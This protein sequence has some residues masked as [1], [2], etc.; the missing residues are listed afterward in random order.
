MNRMYI[1]L[2]TILILS[3]ILLLNVQNISSNTIISAMDSKET[4]DTNKIIEEIVEK[5]DLDLN[6]PRVLYDLYYSG[7]VLRISRDVL[8]ELEIMDKSVRDIVFGYFDGKYWHALPIR[9][10][11]ERVESNLTTIYIIPQKIDRDT[12]VEIKLPSKQP[13]LVDP[14]EH[15]PEFARAANCR[16]ITLLDKRVGKPIGYIYLFIGGSVRWGTAGLQLLS[17]YDYTTV[18]EYFEASEPPAILD[19]MNKLGYSEEIKYYI[20]SQIQNTTVELGVDLNYN[21]T[22]EEPIPDKGGGGGDDPYGYNLVEVRPQPLESM[23][24]E[25]Y[26]FD[27]YNND[28]SFKIHAVDP[29]R[30]IK[31]KVLR[32]TIVIGCTN[33]NT[34]DKDIV[35]TLTVKISCEGYE[36]EEELTLLGDKPNILH[37]QF[38][39]SAYGVEIKE[40][41]IDMAI[42]PIVENEKWRFRIYPTFYINWHYDNIEGVR[43]KP[44]TIYPIVRAELHY[45]FNTNFKEAIHTIFMQPPPQLLSIPNPAN[46]Y[47]YMG[48]DV[49]TYAPDYVY[50]LYVRI[51]IGGFVCKTATLWSSGYS[52]GLN[53]GMLREDIALL[54]L[55]YK[56]VPITVKTYTYQDIDYYTDIEVYIEVSEYSTTSALT[57]T[58]Y[59]IKDEDRIL[60]TS[61]RE[62]DDRIWKE[63]IRFIR[64]TTVVTTTMEHLGVLQEK[65]Y[66]IT[67]SRETELTE[68]PGDRDYKLSID[69]RSPE[70]VLVCYDDYGYCDYIYNLGV[71]EA[72][73]DILFPKYMDVRDITRAKAFKFKLEGVLPELPEIPPPMAI[74][75]SKIPYINV[76][77]TAYDAFIW[78]YNMIAREEDSSLTITIDKDNDKITIHWKRGSFSGNEFEGEIYID[79]VYMSEPKNGDIVINV[80][81]RYSGRTV[82][83]TFI[84]KT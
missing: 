72:I 69:T 36:M 19:Y 54:S 80:E 16:V 8:K 47:V 64:G 41:Q 62:D 70:E 46:K 20:V 43:A 6:D 40:V 22:W 76:A 59:Y 73:I 39:P 37:V 55:L 60:F 84:A 4:I 58:M 81:M 57:R 77:T 12:I 29:Y 52:E 26:T 71:E 74:V 10:Y 66:I 79:D 49:T 1:P 11:N 13:I 28:Y 18:N 2:I 5:L 38:T 75:L 48:L 30:D 35:R 68:L 21:V 65:S 50:P 25:D 17:T 53:I 51:C 14:R 24:R 78:T 3:L 67:F 23:I 82:D 44:L 61:T 33:T 34:G 42:T 56:A 63:E 45:G 32:L 83:Y 15:I 31:W 9:M 7:R 27:F